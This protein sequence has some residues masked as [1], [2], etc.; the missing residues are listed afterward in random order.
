MEEEYADAVEVAFRIVAKRN[1]QANFARVVRLATVV[2]FVSLLRQRC[3]CVPS[4]SISRAE[5]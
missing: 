4:S 2:G 5:S 3:F 1:A